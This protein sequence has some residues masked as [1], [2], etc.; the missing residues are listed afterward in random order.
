ME[1]KINEVYLL[2]MM[3]GN[4]TEIL[5]VFTN[6]KT[7][8]ESYDILMKEDGRCREENDIGK[9]HFSQKPI[10][11]KIPLDKFLGR[12]EEWYLENRYIFFAEIE[13][14]ETVVEEIQKE[15]RDV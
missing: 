6:G 13:K 5:G 9:R 11:Y 2:C 15:I 1:Q 3:F 8:L 7:L 12:K 14:Y 10:I 4:E